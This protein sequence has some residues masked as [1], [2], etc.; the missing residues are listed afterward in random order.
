MRFLLFIYY[1]FNGNI[2]Y[3]VEYRLDGCRAKNGVDIEPA[4]GAKETF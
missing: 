2:W 1:G 3:K 4:R